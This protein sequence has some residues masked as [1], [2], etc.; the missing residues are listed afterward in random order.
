MPANLDSFKNDI[1]NKY[2]ELL[3]DYKGTVT[4]HGPYID[5]K[6]SSFDPL[7][8]EVCLKRYS[9]VLDIAMRLKSPYLVIHSDYDRN[10]SY[11]GYNDYFIDQTISLWKN[12]IK[13]F[14]SA[15]VT[16]VIENIHNP[17][18]SSIKEIIK[19]VGS[20][21]L[22]ACLDLGHAH[23]FGKVSLND[24]I[25]CYGED[26]KYI[27]ISDNNGEKDQHLSL[28]EGNINFA[29]FFQRLKEVV[30]NPI[31]ILEIHGDQQTEEKNL[32][33]LRKFI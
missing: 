19:G 27:H 30:N 16:A 29:T 33:Y 20:K 21:N 17:D 14:E 12:L 23:A 15:G 22:A 11:E 9:Q 31:S 32:M 8:R 4:L 6:P 10:P 26:L 25:N 28:G 7:V 24:W 3:K 5:L 2:I 18:G 1:L 13:E